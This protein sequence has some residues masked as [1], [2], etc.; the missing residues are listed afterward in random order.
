MEVL[1]VLLVL[2]V[3]AAMAA[4]AFRS[5]RYDVKQSQAKTAALK[6]AEASREYYQVSRGQL[7][8]VCFTPTTT[9]GKNI[10]QST[11]CNNPAA[12]GI[13]R[14][15]TSVQTVGASTGEAANAANHDNAE[16]LFAC[17]YLSAKDF[18]SLPYTFCTFRPTG[19]LP[20]DSD[21]VTPIDRFYAVAYAASDEAGRKYFKNSNTAPLKGYIYVDGSMESKDTY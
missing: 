12:T 17:G 19:V 11:T 10:M 18:I 8:Q 3:V 16:R 14:K 9:D 7:L 5:V 4:P 6:L 15:N 2:A 13:P 21:P 1:A 20:D